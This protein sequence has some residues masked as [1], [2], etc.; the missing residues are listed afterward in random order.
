MESPPSPIETLRQLKQMLD[1]GA[2]TATEFE[3]LKQQLVFGSAAPT[4]SA[5][6]AVPPTSEAPIIDSVVPDALPADQA[7]LLPEPEAFSPE[8]EALSGFPLHDEPAAPRNYLNLV[9]AVG[10]LLAL[11]GLVLYLNLNQHDSEHISSTSL[12]PADSTQV[13]ETGPQAEQNIRLSTEPETIRVAPAHPAIPI[14]PLPP[15]AP[16]AAD[17]VAAPVSA[18]DS[19]L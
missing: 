11:L 4:A 5:N 12:T 2:L 10:G 6:Q 8:P 14:A 1:D 16:A 9:L 3:A 19:A 13:I 7:D 15:A 17:S 18:P